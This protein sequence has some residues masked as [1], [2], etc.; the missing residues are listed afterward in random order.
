[1]HDLVRRGM[2]R[3]AAMAAIATAIAT[4]SATP[5]SSAPYPTPAFTTIETIHTPDA[6]AFTMRARLGNPATYLGLSLICPRDTTRPVEVTVYFGEVPADT[7]L[8][9]LAVHD[10]DR[11]VV[12]FGPAVRGTPASG[13]HS[14]R[15]TDPLDALEFVNLAL[16]PGSLVSNGH[17]SFLNRVP[18]AENRRV[19]NAYIRCL[20]ERSR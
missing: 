12:R 10:P 3:F 17:R 7:R 6:L 14:P 8:V 13:F 20:Q 5:A 1:M 15:L 18:K 9:Q 19:R 11:A 2:T 16:Q 4:A